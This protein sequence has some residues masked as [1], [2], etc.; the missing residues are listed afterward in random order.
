M[1]QTV[2]LFEDTLMIMEDNNGDDGD[3]SSGV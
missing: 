3:E 2:F 1:M